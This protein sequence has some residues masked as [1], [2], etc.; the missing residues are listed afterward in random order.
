[1]REEAKA[2]KE[3][4]K[5]LANE[6]IAVNNEANKSL[7]D[8]GIKESK[9]S[10]KTPEQSAAENRMKADLE[11]KQRAKEP[12]LSQMAQQDIEAKTLELD[13]T[14]KV[15]DA[16]EEGYAHNLAQLQLTYTTPPAD[17]VY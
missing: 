14:P 1:M 10:K 12:Y 7:A 13:A 16:M 5:R 2:K 17:T 4:I 11:A 8:A 15:L 9:D 6:I 3:E